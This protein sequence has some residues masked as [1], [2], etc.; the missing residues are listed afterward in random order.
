MS[1]PL[2]AHHGRLVP[3]TALSA[4]LALSA[5]VP[6]GGPAQAGGVPVPEFVLPD[7]SPAPGVLPMEIVSGDVNG[8]GHSD[9]VVANNGPAQVFDGGV[10]V[11]LGD[12]AGTLAAP[13]LTTLPSGWG[14]S[15]VA[16]IDLDG[17][18]LHDVVAVGSTTG[19]FGPIFVL[20]AAGGGS[21]VLERSFSNSQEL[22]LAVADFDG[23]GD[24]DFASSSN[25]V[26]KITVFFGDGTGRFPDR[27]NLTPPFDT[28]DFTARDLEGDGDVDL[29]GATGGSPFSMLNDGHGTFAPGKLSSGL[30]GIDMALDDLDGDGVLD[31]AIGNASAGT[32]NVGL[33]DGDGTFTQVA[34][35]ADLAL[36]VDAVGS[37]DVT[38][39]GNVDLI[40]NSDTNTTNLHVGR[41]D[42]TFQPPIRFVTGE[43]ELV[44]ADLN[45][46]PLADLLAVEQDPGFVHASLAARNGF[47]TARVTET[48]NQGIYA[49]GDVNADGRLDLVVA[50]ETIPGPGVTVMQASVFLNRGRG[51]F[52]APV[53]TEIDEGPDNTSV[54][55]PRLADV[56]LDG[57]PDLTGVF[58][59]FTP[60]LKKIYTLLGNGDGTFGPLTLSSPNAGNDDLVTLEDIVDVTEDGIPDVLSR[61]LAELSVWPGKGDGTFDGPIH[62]GFSQAG[63]TATMVADFTGDGHLD[64]VIAIVTGTNDISSSEVILEEGNGDGAFFESQ[65]ITIPNNVA[66]GR[67]ADFDG[68]GL[69]DVATI[70]E[71]G[72]NAG[73]SGLFVFKNQGGSFA[74]P[75][76]YQRGESGIEVGDLNLDGAVEVV[77]QDLII[78]L[79]GGDGTF[80]QTINL[81]SSSTVTEIGDFTGDG[82]L[83]L[84]TPAGFVRLGFALYVNTT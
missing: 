51:R 6:I 30:F 17:D 49:K 53:V 32:V 76:N 8:D 57:R 3:R 36:Q 9:A 42:G 65:D 77:T 68:D 74:S 1:S 22:Q 75:A 44:A 50:G 72:T 52:G 38:G 18:G 82:R 63:H 84:I 21:L 41:G 37:G 29:I 11:L 7:P 34:T 39:D 16:T 23:D 10:S 14:A 19:S 48:P 35:I 69:P 55:F 24:S 45:G 20:L 26:N 4:A 40:S 79:N 62:S 13:T 60:F 58:V 71:R 33:G 80:D 5:L 56:N 47:L 25:D 61:T 12:G 73:I 59:R 43:D 28:W 15:E 67:A 31:V 70:G 46:D 64:V 81:L 83:D 66:D 2:A 27:L 78:S 54:G